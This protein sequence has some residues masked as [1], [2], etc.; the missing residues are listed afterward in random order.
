M[1][2]LT[3][4]EIVQIKLQLFAEIVR[5]TADPVVA[6]ASANRAFETLFGTVKT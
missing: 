2:S 4:Q 3:D 1:D 6:M 5:V